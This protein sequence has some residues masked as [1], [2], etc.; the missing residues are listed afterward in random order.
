M[1]KL[2]TI[3][4]SVLIISLVLLCIPTKGMAA[5]YTGSDVANIAQKYI[6]AP[7]LYGGTTP[8]GFD[9]SGYVQYVYKQVGVTLPR[10]SKDQYNTGRAVSANSLQ[11]GDLVFF[12]TTNSGGV[13]HVGIYIGNNNFISST[14]SSGVKVYSLNNSYWKPLYLG[15]KRILGTEVSST[16]SFTDLSSSHFA[17]YAIH[18]L[19]AQG[20]IN[21]YLDGTFRPS[22]SV[23]RGQAAAIINRVLNYTP[24]NTTSFKD[25]SSSHMFAKDIAAMK[26]LGIIQGFTDGTYRPNDT[27]TRAQMA[28]IVHNA[29]NL[30]LTIST[31]QANGI[32]SDISPSYWAFSEIVVMNIIDQTTGFKTTKYRPTDV[33]TRADFAAAV[34]NGTLAK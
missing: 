4:S 16:S 6:G 17:Y 7:Y 27:L 10:T 8:S 34:Y 29:F 14:T 18:N 5:T 25:V 22:N 1:K 3:L 11:L 33:A 30:K 28:V 2:R 15:A 19:S 31:S 32:Y 12:D 23:T 20:V 24:K 13:S 9:C 26:E 21:G